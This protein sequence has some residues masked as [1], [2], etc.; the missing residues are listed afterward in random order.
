MTLNQKIKMLAK[1]W[2]K[3]TGLE[4]EYSYSL[5]EGMDTDVTSVQVFSAKNEVAFLIADL[6][7]G[8]E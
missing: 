5:K 3:Y 1:A 6:E 7:D 4:A 2:V 8:L